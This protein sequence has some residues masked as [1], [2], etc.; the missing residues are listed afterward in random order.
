[1]AL[2]LPERSAAICAWPLQL[3]FRDDETAW[4]VVIPMLSG[5][6]MVAPVMVMMMMMMMMMMK[7]F[8]GKL[9]KK[10]PWKSNYL[11]ITQNKISNLDFLEIF[12]LKFSVEF[13]LSH[14]QPFGVVGHSTSLSIAIYCSQKKNHP[15]LWEC[16]FIQVNEVRNLFETLASLEHH[17]IYIRANYDVEVPS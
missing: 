17:L 9:A 16:I 15:E 11:R 10:T 14:V 2:H 4:E 3:M 7:L 12:I 1:L 8:F 13:S 5:G 6:E